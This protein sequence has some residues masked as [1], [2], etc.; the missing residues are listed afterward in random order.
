M[1]SDPSANNQPVPPTPD[2]ATAFEQLSQMTQELQVRVVYYLTSIALLSWPDE[3]GQCLSSI[4]A[5]MG[6]T[7]NTLDGIVTR[8]RGYGESALSQEDIKTLMAAWDL[9][10]RVTGAGGPGSLPSLLRGEFSHLPK[11]VAA[12]CR[13]GL[14]GIADSTLI[15][16]KCPLNQNMLSLV[17]PEQPDLLSEEYRDYM[18]KELQ[19]I[20]DT[21]RGRVRAL[22]DY[23]QA[24][25]SAMMR[26]ATT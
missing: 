11:L 4:G 17:A 18:L 8:L 6:C 10:R 23:L 19:G 9:A 20:S 7:K 14:G 22:D 13:A 1:S 15:L 25:G 21:C 12:A 16:P 5:A 3:A 26:V 2:V 24:V